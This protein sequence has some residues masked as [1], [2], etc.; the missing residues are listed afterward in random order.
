M[1]IFDEDPLARITKSIRNSYKNRVFEVKEVGEWLIIAK[2]NKK[3]LIDHM[4]DEHNFMI[5]IK[6]SFLKR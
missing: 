1:K 2:D 4:L 5:H 6:I 3:D